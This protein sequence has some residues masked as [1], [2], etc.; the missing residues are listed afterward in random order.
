MFLFRYLVDEGE[1]CLCCI[2]VRGTAYISIFLYCNPTT[3][4]RRRWRSS[5]IPVFCYL[6]DEGAF[7]R[8][9]CGTDNISIFFIATQ[10]L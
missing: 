6:V 7:F 2:F 1:F 5:P 4:M 9:G 3:T 10:Q 8:F